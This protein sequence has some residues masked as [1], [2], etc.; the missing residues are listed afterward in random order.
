VKGA[1]TPEGRVSAMEYQYRLPDPTGRKDLEYYRN[2]ERRGYLSHLV[3]EGHNPS[4]WFR[5]ELEAE[6][7]R[8]RA[9]EEKRDRGPGR[10]TFGKDN[11]MW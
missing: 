10:R 11:Q 3:K 9:R 8:E 6:E 5:S 7:A 2:K 1:E 4:L